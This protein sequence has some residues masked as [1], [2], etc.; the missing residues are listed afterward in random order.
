MKSQKTIYINHHPSPNCE[1]RPPGTVIDTVIVHATVINTLADV[2][3]KFSDPA[4]KASAHYTID[5]DGTIASHVPEEKKA[6]HAGESR[7]PDGRT[8][9]NAFSIGIELVNLNDGYDPYP[10]PQVEALRSLIKAIAHRHPIKHILPHYEVAHPP[11]R[12][13]DPKGFDFS[14]IKIKD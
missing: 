8:G 7:I 6:W 12:K 1:V 11:G 4:A 13:S 3:K 10:E 2:I 14:K 5:R 9:V